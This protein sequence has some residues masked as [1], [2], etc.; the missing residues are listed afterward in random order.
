[1]EQ[2]V[3]TDASAR[4]VL[5]CLANYADHRGKAA[6]PSAATLVLDTG[7][8]ER[9]V[10]AKLDALEQMGVIQKGNQAVVAAYIERGDRRPVC[11]DLNIERHAT[12]APRDERGANDAA[13]GCNPCSH[14]VQMAQERGAATAPN[15]SSKPS[16]KPS[17]KES[18]PRDASRPAAIRASKPAK[19]TLPADFAISER[20]RNWA[21]ENGYAQLEK[22][23]AA[24]VLKAESKGYTYAN[25]DSAFMTAVRE[26]WAG[27]NGKPAAQQQRAGKFDPVAYV[28][29]NRIS[30]GRTHD[31]IDV[32]AER[33][34]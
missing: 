26:D 24:F 22:H 32:E 27:L 34:A 8:S 7:L 33:V 15:T 6:F 18:K 3:V 1:M 4:H 25:W 9:T 16:S 29:R 31:V 28:N 17:I 2:Q 14:G 12:A 19:V 13:T 11:Y 10:R 21:A 20:V 30:N 23:F 5:L